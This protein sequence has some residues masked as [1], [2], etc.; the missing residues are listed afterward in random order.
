MRPTSA[1]PRGPI[2]QRA[3]D[4]HRR[5]L[6]QGYIR[7]QDFASSPQSDHGS[8]RRHVHGGGGIAQSATQTAARHDGQPVFQ[9]EKHAGV[10]TIPNAALRF[11]PK[12][13]QVRES[14]RA[15]LASSSGDA[16]AN[17]NARTTGGNEKSASASSRNQRYV[18]VAEAICCRP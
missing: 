11:Y 3:G 9:I 17:R 5:R 10:L 8:E 13:E 4:F 2:A 15:I 6:P 18:W 7:G 14:D 12:P 16:Q 1:D